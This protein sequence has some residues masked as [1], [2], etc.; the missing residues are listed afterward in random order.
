MSRRR[1]AGF[2]EATCQGKVTFATYAE[3]KKNGVHS[4]RARRNGV[5]PYKCPHCRLFH[6]GA[7]KPGPNKRVMLE[8]IR[9]MECME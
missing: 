3:A 7:T 5:H 4:E 2:K 8:R 9:E 1:G 6:V